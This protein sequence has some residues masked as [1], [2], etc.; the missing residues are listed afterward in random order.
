MARAIDAKG[1]MPQ[2]LSALNVDFLNAV[3]Y[4]KK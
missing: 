1:N 2:R 4:R 3:P